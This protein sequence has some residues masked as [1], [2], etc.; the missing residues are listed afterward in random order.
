MKICYSIIKLILF[1]SALLYCIQDEYYDGKHWL[2]KA[3]L[4]IT[5]LLKFEGLPIIYHFR[6][7]V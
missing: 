5:L 3:H 2:F 1:Y 4:A 7:A 6:D